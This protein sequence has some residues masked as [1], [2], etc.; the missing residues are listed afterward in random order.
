VSNT[1]GVVGIARTGESKA[2]VLSGASYSIEANSNS[3]DY[4]V[5]LDLPFPPI[6]PDNPWQCSCNADPSDPYRCT[7]TNQQP[8]QGLVNFF[9][10]QAGST[11]SAWFQTLGGSSFAVNHIESKVP[12]A[13]CT[14][15][16]CN[17][18]FILRDPLG[19]L[20]SAGF[21]LTNAGV[22][23]TSQ[24]GGVYIH[25][26][27]GRSNALQAQALGV[28]VPLEDYEYFYKKFG[29]SAV[30]LTG[31]TKPIV[32]SDNLG[33]FVYSGNL[34]IDE[35]NPWYLGNEEQIVV[36]VD[37]N[38]TLN[39]TTG[40]E[41]R[42]TTVA[43]G[44]DGFLMFI[45]SGNMTITSQV[46]YDNIYAQ[47]SA[48]DIANVEGV[49]VT[50]GIFTVEGVTGVTDKK[51]IG[52]GTFVG[53]SGVDLQRSFADGTLP[54]LDNNA[55]AESFIFRPDFIINAPRSIKSS[56]QTWREIAP[57]FSN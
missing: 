41:N 9:I 47:A 31:V 25:E 57:Q 50:D 20:D 26:A 8:D 4:T 33:V 22:V 38:L 43:T 19:T 27:D 17:P 56:Q 16:T 18:A 14:L 24:T 3:N 1:G 52:A 51:F 28:A 42:L 37:G 15:P 6:D 29:G 46:G 48:P 45:I 49:F 40:G 11:S 2:Q 13:S 32:S 23:V 35:T 34:S 10:K 5:T 30:L 55:P 21:P 36:F 12:F 7:Y 53:W 39:D 54:N 44:G